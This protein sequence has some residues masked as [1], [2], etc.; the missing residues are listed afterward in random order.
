MGVAA[1]YH[2]NC[3]GLWIATCRSGNGGEA[4]TL[5]GRIRPEERDDD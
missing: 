4:L 2:I 1:G 3:D 5:K